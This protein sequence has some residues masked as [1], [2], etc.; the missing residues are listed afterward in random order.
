MLQLN[1]ALVEKNN[2]LKPPLV[3][4]WIGSYLPAWARLALKL[5]NLNCGLLTILLSSKSIGYVPEVSQQIF[6]EDFYK[7]PK[8]ISHEFEDQRLAF[9]DGFWLK[10]TERFFVLQQFIEKY[11]MKSIFHAELDNLIFDISNLNNK[12]DLVGE[13]FFCPRDS[14]DRGIAS[15]VYINQAESLREMT[16]VFMKNKPAYQNDMLLLGSLL[17]KSNNFY[18]LPTERRFEINKKNLWETINPIDSGGIFD[19][20]SIGQFLFGI[21]PRNCNTILLNGFEN[22]NKGCNLWDLK[23]IN[24]LESGTFQVTDNASSTRLNL[25]NIHIHSKL[26]NLLSNPRRLS[27]VIANIN[28]GKKTIMTLNWKHWRG[29]RRIRKLIFT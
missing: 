6:L 5:S 13:G 24:Y 18:S 4:V 28:S 9:R 23:F 25:Y 12:L 29:I 27:H 20:A 22:E 8:N 19:A 21:D 14:I 11:S 15:L 1:L 2:H 3:Y 16:N 26:F 17:K 10:T 7:P